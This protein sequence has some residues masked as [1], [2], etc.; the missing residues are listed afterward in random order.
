LDSIGYLLCR[1]LR[2][3]L[4]GGG[5]YLCAMYGT[6]SIFNAHYALA[7]CGHPCECGVLKLCA[8]VEVREYLPKLLA[9]SFKT[10][11]ML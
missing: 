4:R 6:I 10:C 11:E 8:K 1:F 2:Y 7:R 5:I 9:L 3:D